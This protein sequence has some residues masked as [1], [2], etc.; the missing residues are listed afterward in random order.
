MTAPKPKPESVRQ[1]ERWMTVC[2]LAESAGLCS[3]CASQFAWGVQGGAGGFSSVHPPCAAC[4]VVMLYWP[5]VRPNG[6]RS[7]GGDVSV[8]GTWVSVGSTG[9]TAPRGGTD[10]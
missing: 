2:R 6:W 9:R 4:V 5:V 7:P 8:R 10:E 1:A 3:R